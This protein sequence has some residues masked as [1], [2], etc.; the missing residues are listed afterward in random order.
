MPVV[1]QLATIL[2]VITTMQQPNSAV[3]N[4]EMVLLSQLL[5]DVMTTTL[6]ITMD[7]RRLVPSKLLSPV[8]DNRVFASLLKMLS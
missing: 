3:L 7:V 4:V 5:K 1:V 8:K 2:K 6:L